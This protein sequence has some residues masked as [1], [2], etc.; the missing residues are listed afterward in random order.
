MTAGD[1]ALQIDQLADT[2]PNAQKFE[3]SLLGLRAQLV[4]QGDR[5]G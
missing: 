1:T 5:R 4:G 2:H 3:L